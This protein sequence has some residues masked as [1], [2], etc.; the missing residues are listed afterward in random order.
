MIKLKS[1]LHEQTRLFKRGMRDPQVGTKT[2]PIAKIQ[3]KLIDA[4]MM[5]KI[6]DTSYGIYGPKTKAA[7]IQFQKKQFPNDPKEWD[8]I[9]GPKTTA[10]LD[11]LVTVDDFDSKIDFGTNVPGS[12]TYVAGFDRDEIERRLSTPEPSSNDGFYGDI[13]KSDQITFKP[14]WKDLV[15][16]T[17][18]VPVCDAP[19]LE[20]KCARFVHLVD[21]KIGSIGDAWTAWLN[22][23]PGKRNVYS[24]MDSLDESDKKL[25]D[26]VLKQ[27]KSN[28]GGVEKGPLIKKERKKLVRELHEKFVNKYSNNLPKEKLTPGS[29]VGI[30]WPPSDFHETALRESAK[31]ERYAPFNT[32]VGIVIAVKDDVPIILHEFGG[33]GMAEPFDNLSSSAEIVWIKQE[34]NTEKWVIAADN[35]LNQFT[36]KVSTKFANLTDMIPKVKNP[37]Q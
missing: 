9:V 10:E 5:S 36:R 16:S 3:Q 7:V 28:G 19:E 18:R 24:M 25:Y 2:G 35:V 26:N 13:Q 33:V 29:I 34:N 6:P 32:H 22:P 37:F 12:S 20:D 11:K 4:G 14:G 8:G 31:R 1:L 23:V 27:I 15:D 17:K 21:D 30:F